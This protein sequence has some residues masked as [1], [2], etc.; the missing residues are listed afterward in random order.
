MM[1]ICKKDCELF[2]CGTIIGSVIGMM[3]SPKCGKEMREDMMKIIEGVDKEF[4]KTIK[5][6]EEEINDLDKEKNFDKAK[7]KAENILEQADSLVDSA[8]KEKKPKLK[9]MASD[10]QKKARAVT[11]SVLDNLE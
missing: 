10:M 9:K 3:L 1:K 4:K 5:T 7:E 8:I 2:L 11:E 6:L